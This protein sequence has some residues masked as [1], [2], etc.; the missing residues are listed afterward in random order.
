GLAEGFSV[1]G[2]G[3]ISS[4]GATDGCSQDPAKSGMSCSGLHREAY[5]SDSAAILLTDQPYPSRSGRPGPKESLSSTA[6][7]PHTA[8]AAVGNTRRP[9]HHVHLRSAL[10]RVA[11]EFGGHRHQH[12][13]QYFGEF[14][15]EFQS[16][17]GD[18]RIAETGEP[19]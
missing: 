9:R 12:K 1:A 11:L 10:R 6:S 8:S 13:L 14:G 17:R 7:I 2:A 18:A 5:R 4:G 15:V 16:H 3:R 19:G